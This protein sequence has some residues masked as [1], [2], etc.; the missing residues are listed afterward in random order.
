VL[1]AAH[2]HAHP[3]VRLV[4]DAGRG[5]QQA[6]FRE[7]PVD[8]VNAVAQGVHFAVLNAGIC[9]SSLHSAAGLGGLHHLV[10]L[11]NAVLQHALVLVVVKNIVLH[12]FVLLIVVC[13]LVVCAFLAIGYHADNG[14]NNV[15]LLLRQAV[16][17]FLDGFF[18]DF[19][20]LGVLFGILLVLVL[21]FGMH[22][23]VLL[24]QR[25]VIGVKAMSQA[26][27]AV[28]IDKGL[29]AF[30]CTPV[31]AML[32]DLVDQCTRVAS[33]QYQTQFP[34]HTVHHG[35]ACFLQSICKDAHG[36]NVAAAHGFQRTL[37]AGAVVHLHIG[38]NAVFPVLQKCVSQYVF[39]AG[40]VVVPHHRHLSAIVVCKG[41]RGDGQSVIAQG[42]RLRCIAGKIIVEFLRHFD[43]LNL[44]PQDSVKNLSPS[45]KAGPQS[46]CRLPWR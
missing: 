10:D 2:Y 23:L 42:V 38:I 22:D 25:V 8:V 13:F 33:G 29:F 24:I 16:E 6:I 36:I 26:D 18:G 37:A 14:V 31:C 41:V 39:R 4:N 20:V 5:V 15:L 44:L 40:M 46:P 43:F 21:V 9:K 19:F 32:H 45:P 11:V 12:G 30:V 3:V 35:L 1:H 17:H 27:P 28:G 7:Q 34:D